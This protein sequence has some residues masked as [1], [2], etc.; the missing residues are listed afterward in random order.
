MG[1]SVWTIEAEAMVPAAADR[2]VAWW[3]APERVEEARVRFE[4]TGV[5]RFGW[6]E[7]GT[8]DRQI[9]EV[10]WQ[11]KD[12]TQLSR[13]IESWKTEPG[14]VSGSGRHVLQRSIAQSITPRSGKTV[15]IVDA[16]TIVFIET[17]A[18]KTAIRFT[19]T[20][21]KTG[22]PWWERHLPPNAEHSALLKDLEDRAR[23]CQHD[24]GV[25]V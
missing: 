18:D 9:S 17:L 12:G 23:Q 7:V 15:E 22:G 21:T 11:T 16:M 19:T 24:L 1:Q 4:A 10:Q 5:P 13:R 6:N 14:Q 25:I 3:T 8:D 20:R 2:V